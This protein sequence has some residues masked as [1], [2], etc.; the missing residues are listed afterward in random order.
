VRS[1]AAPVALALVLGAADPASA[2]QIIL[3]SGQAITGTLAATSLA[4]AV[5]SGVIEVAAEQIIVLMPGEVRLRD[6]QVISGEPVGGVLKLE[7]VRGE[8]VVSTADLRFYRA[9][10][11][12]TSTPESLRGGSGLP[13]V[14][15]YQ[16][17]AP[18]DVPEAAGGQ[19]G[20]PVVESYQAGASSPPPG[21]DPSAAGPV[22][23]TLGASSPK[24]GPGDEGPVPGK[25]LEVVVGESPVYRDAYAT[26]RRV[27]RVEQGEQLVAVDFIDRR[28]RV[29]NTLVLD[30]GYW[31]KVRAA[32]GTEGWV[33]G[34]TVR[35]LP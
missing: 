34:K 21:S 23:A 26:A 11:E 28:L 1:L 30:G 18:P 3:R 22:V 8:I 25:R 2:G 35:V 29:M 19:H 9:D 31:V 24:P 7:T 33:P 10:G 14:S 6:G 27:G 20:L 4:V 17:T 15:A 5:P 32:D 12:G 16:G 13:L